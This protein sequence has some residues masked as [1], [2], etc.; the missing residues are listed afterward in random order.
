MRGTH[1]LNVAGATAQ[2]RFG[3]ASKVEPLR[4]VAVGY[5][6]RASLQDRLNA[7]PGKRAPS[8]DAMKSQE[9]SVTP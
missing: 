3:K 2:L 6:F 4:F 9:G 5:R 7:P 8:A 1:R